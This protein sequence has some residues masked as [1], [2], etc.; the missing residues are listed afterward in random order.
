MDRLV[1]DASSAGSAKKISFEELLESLE[2]RLDHLL[3]SERVMHSLVQDK[4][5]KSA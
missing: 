1:I 4:S 3:N 2:H 5:K